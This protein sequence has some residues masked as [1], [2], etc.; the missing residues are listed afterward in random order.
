MNKLTD[1]LV[2]LDKSIAAFGGTQAALARALGVT[3]TCV[4]D[5]V[6]DKKYEYVPV[7]QAYRLLRNYPGLIKEE[8]P[9][10]EVI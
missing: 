8:V 7:L 1:P 10:D 2:R 4:S 6:N 5:W 9:E 3:R